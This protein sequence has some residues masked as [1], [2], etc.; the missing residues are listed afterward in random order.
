MPRITIVPAGEDYIAS[1]AERMRD[2][3][4]AEVWASSR[5]TPQKSLE[6]SLSHSSQAWTALIDDQPE[7]MFGVMD[8]NILTATGAPWLLGTDAVVTYN[9]QFLRRSLWWRGKLLEQ[10]D[11]LKNFVHDD[12]V[13]SKRWLQWLGFTLHDPIRAG[14]GGEPFRLF[15]MRR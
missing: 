7:V 8:I 14:A 4:R 9:R 12:N 1:I 6:T 5:S 2:E 11:V 3:D 13:V 15:E 10:Y